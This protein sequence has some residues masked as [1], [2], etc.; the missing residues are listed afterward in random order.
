MKGR[1]SAEQWTDFWKA[2]SVTTFM[3]RF[4]SNYDGAIL[5][6]WN[7][8][9]ERLDAQA[10]VVD[11]ATGNGALALL[12]AQFSDANEKG[13]EVI[14]VD[15]ASTDPADM[16]KEKGLGA[17]LESIC[18]VTNTRLEETGL[19]EHN[20]DLVCSQ[21]GFEYGDTEK[22]VREAERLLKEDGGIFA[23]MM[24][25]EGSAI[26][27]QAQEGVRQAMQ[28]AKSG[29]LEQ[30]E[31][32]LRAIDGLTET[33]ADP[34]TD[35]KCEKL[36][37]TTNNITEKLH[38]AQS[39]YKDPGQIAYYLTNAMSLFNKQQFGD[40]GL[41]EKLKL[42]HTIQPETDTYMQ[43]MRDMISAALNEKEISA[44]ETALEAKGITIEKSEAIDF[45]GVKFCHALVASRQEHGGR[46]AR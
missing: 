19:Q 31:K 1:L 41:D 16:L 26:M 38:A 11:L 20:F 39:Q 17:P 40:L 45:E 34:A 28:C 14:G 13:F 6:F 9:F 25:V 23:V 15:Y 5:E 36:R 33:G 22:A 12:A 37:H 4:S 3:G 21:F 32:L 10:A 27:Q 18:F 29:L 42:L 44:I 35:D 46:K 7:R 8:I 43:R 24:H 30:V 2:G